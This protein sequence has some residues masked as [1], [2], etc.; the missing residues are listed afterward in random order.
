MS[1]TPRKEFV[2]TG[3]HMLGI[4]LLFFGVVISVNFYMA[5]QAT[6]SWSGL[7]VEN[8]Y[9]ASQEFNGKVA[10]AKALAAS[11]VTGSLD[12]S[13]PDIRY[14]LSH[15]VEGPIMADAVTLKFKRPVG[16]VQDFDLV[17]E[18]AG[19]GVFAARHDVPDGTWIIEVDALR[20][21]T[22]ILHHTSRITIAGGVPVTGETQ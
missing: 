5:W 20:D 2:F 19:E 9:I 17:M 13:G 15:P 12:I 8:T 22:R 21:G 18:P 3:W 16:E 6:R 7:V 11:G 1:T 4:M 10:E 14:Q